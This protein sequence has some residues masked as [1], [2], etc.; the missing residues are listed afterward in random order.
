MGSRSAGAHFL[1][2]YSKNMLRVGLTGGIGSGKS[3]VASLLKEMGAVV[4]DSDQLAR[5]VVNPGSDGL[6]KVVDR[7]GPSII[8]EGSLDRAALAE[9]VFNDEAARK[10]LE[11]ITHP[12]IRRRFEEIASQAPRDAII[13]NEVPLLVEREMQK[14][15]DVVVTVQASEDV[16]RSRLLGRGMASEQVDQ[17]VKAQASDEQRAAVSDVIIVND[18]ELAD[19]RASVT[20]LWF[21]RLKPYEEQRRMKAGRPPQ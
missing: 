18:G 7:F 8:K 15:F 4:I 2:R 19:L 13:V 3:A 12:L 17:R 16:K 14:D 5:E 6:A 10:D 21:E 20:T 9:I 11:A 1:F